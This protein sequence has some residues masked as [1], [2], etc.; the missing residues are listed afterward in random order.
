MAS[1]R[2]MKKDE[3]YP[4][5]REF[6]G[7]GMDMNRFNAMGAHS[8]GIGRK[9]ENGKPTNTLALRVYVSKKLPESRLET[10]NMIPKKVRHFSRLANKEIN[11][12]TDVIEVPPPELEVIDPT[13]K[14]RPAP[15]G[16]S[17]GIPS[18]TAGTLG[19]WVWDKTDDTIVMLTNDHIIGDS[20]GVGIVQ[21]GVFDG[22]SLPGDR[23][24]TTKRRIVRSTTVP[25]DVDCAIGDVDNT[26]D[27]D[28]RVEEIGPA[29]Y[30][31]ELAELDML[32]EKYGRTTSHT[33]GE[34]QDID[35]ST[36]FGGRS[37]E[38]CIYVDVV[39]PSIDWSKGGDSGSLVFSQTPIEPGSEIKPAVGLHF[40]GGIGATYG[41]ECKIQNVFQKL[42]LTT[43]CSG[44]FA[45][46]IEA[47]F[48]A[49]EEGV[50]SEAAQ[51][52]LLGLSA[53]ATR[54]ATRIKP[55]ITNPRERLFAA[56]QRFHA[57]IAR[58][59]QAKLLG[60][61]RGRLVTKF[62]DDYRAPILNLL[63][64]DR[65]I[66][67]ATIKTLRPLVAGA[68]TTTDVLNRV[69]TD[70]DL[71]QLKLL[72]KQVSSRGNSRVKA[73]IKPVL[74]LTSSASGKSI[75]SILNLKL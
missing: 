61:K 10:A 64:Q 67:R 66:Q 37:Y 27:H 40:A 8:I 45:A 50:V 9:M 52:R 62:V 71:K 55:F 69:I 68:T 74:A 49:E 31:T 35:Y 39:S 25:N 59:V 36:S 11:L 33:Y 73:A 58:D 12:V 60:S 46:F 48:D 15:G 20:A 17:V 70:D 24:G 63:T 57:G 21:P 6:K 1:Q 75:A 22:G 41:I 2:N 30:A 18:V 13:D 28:L 54:S 44:A 19:G 7:I 34:V 43:L 29:V 3:N 16:V 47:L 4:L 42:D 32:V 23:I 38:D 65:D 14:F 51:G 26:A 72:A 5:L 56:N 53:L